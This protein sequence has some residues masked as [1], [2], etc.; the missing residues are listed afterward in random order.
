MLQNNEDKNQNGI[1]D[2]FEEKQDVE[3]FEPQGN[4]FDN[5]YMTEES[6]AKNIP[7]YKSYKWYKQPEE[8]YFYSLGEKLEDKIE[9]GEITPEEL[10]ENSAIQK[11]AEQLTDDN[12]HNDEVSNE[13]YQNMSLD[14]IAALDEKA[15]KGEGNY[16]TVAN[17]M[18]LDEN[19]LMYFEDPTFIDNL[20]EEQKEEVKNEPDKSNKLNLL[21]TFGITTNEEPTIES[22]PIEKAENNPA[23]SGVSSVGVN[24]PSSGSSLSAGGVS[25]TATSGV[26]RTGIKKHSAGGGSSN[27]GIDNSGSSYN[28]DAGRG[29]ETNVEVAERDANDASLN[30]ANEVEHID[31]TL[32]DLGFENSEHKE[33]IKT[34]EQADLPDGEFHSE[35]KERYEL[36]DIKDL[37]KKNGGGTYLPFKFSLDGD[38]VMVSQIGTGRKEPFDEFLKHEPFA[39]KQIVEMMNEILGQHNS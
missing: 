14:E 7:D 22:T 8:G 36:P 33:D 12:P 11:E 21:K 30:G 16:M 15:M 37:I 5:A 18:G 2:W 32:D 39:G 19:D 9:S 10:P 29:A 6:I 23:I 31:N 3:Q 17:E 4:A 34:D 13:A 35:K 24:I 38:E 27:V 25:K 1:P 26:Y 20:T 28:S